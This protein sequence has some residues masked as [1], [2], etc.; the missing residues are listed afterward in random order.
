LP[1]KRV[2]GDLLTLGHE[3]L[4]FVRCYSAFRRS[5]GDLGPF[6]YERNQMLDFGDIFFRRP[7][8]LCALEGQPSLVQSN[9]G[10]PG[11]GRVAPGQFIGV[12]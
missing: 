9:C 7:E 5:V 1:G 12:A 8:A 6:L 11:D 3:L 10:S 2:R 4:D